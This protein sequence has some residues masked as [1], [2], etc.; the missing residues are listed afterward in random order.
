MALA[1]APASRSLPKGK[2]VLQH[3]AA[4]G[5]V[6]VTA[7]ARAHFMPWRQRAGR[8][9]DLVK[10]KQEVLPAWHSEQQEIIAQLKAYGCS[11]GTPGVNGMRRFEQLRRRLLEAR[12]RDGRRKRQTEFGN[13]KL[14]TALFVQFNKDRARRAVEAA[15]Y[16]GDYDAVLRAVDAGGSANHVTRRGFT[17]LCTLCRAGKAEHVA[18]LIALGAD[19]NLPSPRDGVTPLVLAARLRDVRL[20]GAILEAGKDRGLDLNRPAVLDRDRHEGATALMVL[21]AYGAVA[22]PLMVRMLD[23]GAAPDAVT[24]RGRTALSFACRFRRLATARLLLEEGALPTHMDKGGFTPV[25]WL[26][27]AVLERVRAADGQG[28]GSRAAALLA[29]SGR[30]RRDSDSTGVAESVASGSSSAGGLGDSVS[31]SDSEAS[32]AVGLV[33]A[34]AIDRLMT[35]EEQSILAALQQAKNR[36]RAHAAATGSGWESEED[37]DAMV[38]E[39]ALWSDD[40]FGDDHPDKEAVLAARRASLSDSTGVHAGG[41]GRDGAPGQARGRRP[42]PLLGRARKLQE[43]RESR[44]A[45]ES[46]ERAGAAS[47]GEVQL[48]DTDDLRHATT[49]RGRPGSAESGRGAARRRRELLLGPGSLASAAT[50]HSTATRALLRGAGRLTE[51][52]ILNGSLSTLGQ[53]A[54]TD[55]DRALQRQSRVVF[56]PDT[57]DKE[58]LCG[59]C[60]ELPARFKSLNTNTRLC[61][62]CVLW[63]HKQPGMRHHRIKPLVPSQSAKGLRVR[64]VEEEA[65]GAAFLGGGLMGGRAAGSTLLESLRLG[66][67]LVAGMRAATDVAERDRRAKAEASRAAAAAEGSENLTALERVARARAAREAAQRQAKEEATGGSL[68]DRMRKARTDAKRAAAAETHSLDNDRR[69]LAF[70]EREDLLDEGDPALAEMRARVAAGEPRRAE[71]LRRAK[72]VELD[73]VSRLVNPMEGGRGAAKGGFVRPGSR[74]WLAMWGRAEELVASAKLA[75]RGGDGQQAAEE[76]DDSVGGAER[77]GDGDEGVDGDGDGPPTSVEAAAASVREQAEEAKRKR[78]REVLVASGVPLD[79]LADADDT[80]LLRAARRGGAGDVG[81]RAD[82]ATTAAAHGYSGAVVL[83]AGEHPSGPRTDMLT[84]VSNLPGALAGAYG[85]RDGTGPRLTDEQRDREAVARYSRA[86]ALIGANGKEEAHGGRPGESL[87]DPMRGHGQ[88]KAAAARAAAT[89]SVFEAAG[90]DPHGVGANRN[91]KREQQLRKAALAQRRAAREAAKRR[92][93]EA[94]R[95]RVQAMH[96]DPPELDLAIFFSKHK[97]FGE[98]EKVVRGVMAEQVRVLGVADRAVALTFAVSCLV[99]REQGRAAESERSLEQAKD[100]LAAFGAHPASSDAVRVAIEEGKVIRAAGRSSEE[101]AH[102]RERIQAAHRVQTVRANGKAAVLA[103]LHSGKASSHSDHEALVEAERAARA[104]VDGVTEVIPQPEVD[105]GLEQLRQALQAARESFER[106]C[107]L[108][109]DDI[110]QK[111]VAKASKRARR[112]S[113]TAQRDMQ[114]RIRRG[115]VS[116]QRGQAQRKV[117]EAGAAAARRA[118]ASV[119][120][121]KGDGTNEEEASDEE[122]ADG[123]GEAGRTYQVR[124]RPSREELEALVEE[125]RWRELLRKHMKG[126]GCE[127]EMDFLVAAAAFRERALAAAAGGGMPSSVGEEASRLNQRY[128]ASGSLSTVPVG[129]RRR[130]REELETGANPDTFDEVLRVVR[131]SI[132]RGPLRRFWVSKRGLRY[133][134]ERALSI[135]LPAWTLEQ[136]SKL[137]AP[138]K[139]ELV[140]RLQSWCR[141]VV[142]QIKFGLMLRAAR[143]QAEEEG[144]AEPGTTLAIAARAAEARDTRRQARRAR[145]RRR[146]GLPSQEEEATDAAESAAA[147]GRPAW[148]PQSTSVDGDDLDGAGENAARAPSEAAEGDAAGFGAGGFGPEATARAQAEAAGG[149]PADAASPAGPEQGD[150]DA[151]PSHQSAG[152][153]DEAGNWVDTPSGYYDEAGNWVDTS[154]GYYDQ[155]GNWVDLTQGY[156]DEARRE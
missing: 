13:S 14:R 79:R 94:A 53:E 11:I 16:E 152:H 105:K 32:S 156:Y 120:E 103:R 22:A 19:P 86:L 151:H 54:R 33:D 113:V 119:F 44:A 96:R 47:R 149:P 100:I 78:R 111:R 122:L 95:Q 101:V 117:K 55:R 116:V 4:T 69:Q 36:L 12:E 139:A 68:I 18:A 21:A 26:R 1:V 73:A 114:W 147:A 58:E 59:N 65:V 135:G 123:A 89:D 142:A 5:Q 85:G 7:E 108:D 40:P 10:P 87:L 140:A 6:S 52:E 97:R 155:A 143:L 72:E 42:P 131:V 83:A 50:P 99:S 92:A 38:P 150:H 145:L 130:V 27:C 24:W 41:S 109:E 133:R 35:A 118:R 129:M 98:A 107:M 121:A 57:A 20:M 64:R 91:A 30:G 34:R 45:V 125:P 144:R 43:Q 88:A 51:E 46:K 67:A 148:M 81:A 77:D 124:L 154:T 90:L 115:S 39:A 48:F 37:L 56:A 106:E 31:V 75:G 61:Q 23:A 146:R 2:A 66:R 49:S 8:E 25:D 138:S 84:G 29:A 141:G 93:Q 63:L 134:A 127:G 82:Q 102:L 132:V 126:E 104:E 15:V 60:H 62:R 70:L 74:A 153:Y 137:A 112:A 110:E 71:A 3:D 9:T 28:A 136:V 80:G 128:I 76:D 17:L